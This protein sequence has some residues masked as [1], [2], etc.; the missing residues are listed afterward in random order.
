M[1]KIFCDKCTREINQEDESVV[2]IEHLF[3]YGSPRDG[4]KVEIEL[5]ED[6]FQGVIIDL[7]IKSN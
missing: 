7:R 4:D 1:I 6:C 3:S 2:K 5:C